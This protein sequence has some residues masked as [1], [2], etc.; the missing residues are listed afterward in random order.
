MPGLRHDVA[1]SVASQLHQDIIIEILE[2]GRA[3]LKMKGIN[4]WPF[5]FTLEWVNQCLEKREFFVANVDQETGGVFRLLHT[6]PFFWGDDVEDAIYIHTLAVRRS[7]QGRGIG[8]DLIRWAEDYTARHDRPYL[9]LDCMA[10]NSVLCQ[11]YE[12]AGF[13]SCGM[14]EFQIRNFLYKAQLF[15]KAIRSYT[16]A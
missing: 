1:V 3:W 6:D 13:I 4:Q 16:A 8:C 10:D 5:A 7:W 14:K 9:R 11:Y 2:D 15:Q 12:Q